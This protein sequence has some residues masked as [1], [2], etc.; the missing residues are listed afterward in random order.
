MSFRKLKDDTWLPFFMP[1]VWRWLLGIALTT[2]VVIGFW[3][4]YYTLQL[5][6]L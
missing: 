2:G 5:R 3:I 6:G 4:C 1:V